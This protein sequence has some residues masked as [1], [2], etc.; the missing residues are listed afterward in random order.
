MGV[1]ELSELSGQRG[2]SVGVFFFAGKCGNATALPGDLFVTCAHCLEIADRGERP[3]GSVYLSF[4]NGEEIEVV[5]APGGW[6]HAGWDLAV[7]APIKRMSDAI[8][9]LAAADLLL[10]DPDGKADLLASPFCTN[11]ELYCDLRAATAGD[12]VLASTSDNLVTLVLQNPGD[13]IEDGFSG[14]PVFRLG[15]SRRAL[16]GLIKERD[17]TSPERFQIIPGSAIQAAIDAVVV[18]RSQATPYGKDVTETKSMRNAVGI[19]MSP[20]VSGE[21][22]TPTPSNRGEDGLPLSVELIFSGPCAT[23][24]PGGERVIFGAPKAWL[25]ITHPRHRLD[26]NPDLAL[27][28]FRRG[29]DVKTA[30]LPAPDQESNLAIESADGV[31]P[32]KGHVLADRMQGDRVDLNA[33]L[34]TLRRKESGPTSIDANVLL[35]VEALR[36]ED[37]NGEPL[38]D[39]AREKA[40]RMIA[41][42]LVDRFGKQSEALPLALQGVEVDDD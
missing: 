28:E 9:P 31:E 14:G 35:S 39:K 19:D 20:P 36:I 6:R 1:I 34:G 5:I 10:V 11:R 21:L 38:V 15:Q 29:S 33:F 13:Q 26:K 23:G 25:K 37:E 3:K 18:A 40:I 27:N 41:K 16:A 32:L 8:E 30:F 12:G 42:K 17:E 7:L 22:V 24:R 2:A 4:D